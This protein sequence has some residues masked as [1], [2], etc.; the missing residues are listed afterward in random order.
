MRKEELLEIISNGENSS[1]E[2][3]LDE[4][5][6]EQLAKEIVALANFHGGKIFIGVADNGEIEG[7]KRKN[8]EEWV[9]DTVFGRYVHPVIIPFYEE[10]ELDG[11]KVAVVSFPS[12]ISKPYVVRNNGREDVYI[13]IGSTSRL[14]TREQQAQLYSVGG[15]LHTEVMPVP[16]TS[17]SSLDHVRLENYI[18]DIL[19][20]PSSIISKEEWI[21][22]L[23]GLGFIIK[24]DDGR[25]LSTVAGLLLFGINP[26]RYLKNAG[27]RVMVFPGGDKEY[28]AL[29]DE[30]IDSPL[31]GRWKVSSGV[32]ELIDAGLIEKFIF[33]LS[34]FIS[35]ESDKIDNNLRREKKFIYPVEAIRETVV[36]AFAHR[37]WTRFADVEV[38]GYS[39]RLE[40]IS[41]GAFQNSMTIEKMIAGQR[42]A[43]NPV[44]VEVLRDYGYVDARGMGIRTKVIPLM[45]KFLNKDPVFKAT[46]DYVSVTLPNS[47]T[48]FVKEVRTEYN[49]STN[50]SINALINAPLTRLQKEILEIIRNNEFVTYEEIADVTK[51]DRSTVM[52]NVQKLKGLNLIKRSGS[53]KTGRWIILF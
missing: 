17:L 49:V 35:E 6:P 29:L 4:I 16:G 31:V 25:I 30:I 21:D 41:P 39:D 52:R 11:R 45:K 38:A 27:L 50:A 36:N 15:M 24:S 9:M 43:R 42:C 20:E 1:V 51:R 47:E 33:A 23:S 10:I 26:R 22:R 14:A 40:V 46:E 19:G 8:I 2:F 18:Y 7:I 13:R 44:I 5:R 37:D 53:R 32:K 12:G 28:R 3:K 48:G 34:P